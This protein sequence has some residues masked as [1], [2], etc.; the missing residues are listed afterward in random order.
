MYLDE[1]AKSGVVTSNSVGI[2]RV[3]FT[4]Q[5]P[6]GVPYAVILTCKEPGT[7]V[8]AYPSLE[9][10]TGFTI[11]TMASEP[12]PKYVIVAGVVVYWLV[13]PLYNS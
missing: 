11:T 13:I 7:P 8:V 5:V 10:Q 9:T 12:A 3:V 1:F 4:N 2:A 6:Y